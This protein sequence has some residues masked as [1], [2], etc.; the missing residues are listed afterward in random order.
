MTSCSL[1]HLDLVVML[2]DRYHWIKSIVFSWQLNMEK[3]GKKLFKQFRMSSN[4]QDNEKEHM[5]FIH[6]FIYSFRLENVKLFNVMNNRDGAIEDRIHCMIRQT[7][8][9][10]LSTE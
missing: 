10:K 7:L 4:R 6:L 2:A 5:R 9:R 1:V 8:N 3:H